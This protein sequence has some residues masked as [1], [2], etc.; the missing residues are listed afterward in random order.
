MIS[1]IEKILNFIFPPRCMV[2]DNI[3]E[4]NNT[5]HVCAEC[6][7]RLK[8]INLPVCNYCG[9]ELEDPGRACCYECAVQDNYYD[10]AIC[11]CEYCGII[12]VILQKLKFD[13][14]VEL[15]PLISEILVKKIKQ[16][17]GILKFDIIISVPLHPNRMKQRGYNQSQLIAQYVANALKVDYELNVIEKIRDIP[18]QSELCRA[19]RI[20]NVKGAFRVTMSEKVAGKN[21]LLIDDILTTGST[22][23]ECSKELKKSGA[24]SITVATVATGATNKT[25]TEAI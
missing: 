24:K 6:Y 4:F 16:K 2:C 17:T 20:L 9:K 22:L 7:A 12:K 18:R 1:C 25:V 23:R 5:T 13:N 11:A 15:C 19:D 21:I 8:S 14:R 10:I 3:T